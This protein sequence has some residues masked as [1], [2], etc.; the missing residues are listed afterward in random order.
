MLLRPAKV[1]LDEGPDY[2]CM[3]SPTTWNGWAMPGFTKEQADIFCETHPDTVY[4][5][6]QDAYVATSE[7]DD[8]E[9]GPEVYEAIECDG[10]KLYP[11]GAGCWTWNYPEVD[12]WAGHPVA[13]AWL[14]LDAFVRVLRSD[15]GTIWERVAAAL[16]QEEDEAVLRPLV[17]DAL[18]A[19]V[20]A[21]LDI[22]DN[23]REH[24]TIFAAGGNP[25]V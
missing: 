19:A 14:L 16:N 12:P 10:L 22:T 11:I 9:D 8:P 1:C 2:D 6:A 17:A 7:D 15:T 25:W 23:L 5:A 24:S 20:A 13:G 3:L 4:D 21:G 18:A